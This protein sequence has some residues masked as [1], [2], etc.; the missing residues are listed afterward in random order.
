[1][2]DEQEILIPPFTL[3]EISH[4]NMK[5]LSDSYIK[6]QN[7]SLEE[8]QESLEN[9][10]SLFQD[11]SNNLEQLNY[12]RKRLR[13]SFSKKLLKEKSKIMMT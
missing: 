7:D 10:I 11:Y 1:M 12:S 8:Y 3:M 4:L 6:L 9:F 13:E 2:K 5:I